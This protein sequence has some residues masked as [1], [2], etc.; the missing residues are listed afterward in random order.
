MVFCIL[1]QVAIVLLAILSRI[2]YS[3]YKEKI[4]NSIW[5]QRYAQALGNLYVLDKKEAYAQ[6]EKKVCKLISTCMLV[7]FISS[8]AAEL[9][10]CRQAE[11]AADRE[12]SIVRSDYTG[13]ATSET[14][15]LTM[16]DK[17]Y[18]YT[19]EIAPREYTQAEFIE[20]A[21]QQVKNLEYEILGNNTDFLHIN[22]NLNL[23]DCD[24]TGIFAYV[25]ES[26]H[27]E[28]VTPYGKVCVEELSGT[29]AVNLTVTICYLSYEWKHSFS[30]VVVEDVRRKD[31]FAEVEALLSDIE[32]NTRTEEKITL[33]DTYEA[34][35]IAVEKETSNQAAACIMFGILIVGVLWAGIALQLREER[36][37]RT[38]ALIRSYPFVVNQLWLLLETGMT[39][40]MG[41]R[42]II[43]EMEED[44]LLKK[45]LEYAMHQLDTGNEEAFVYEALGHRL[46]LPEYE[47]FMQH[48]SQH[49]RMGTKDL[50]NLMEM[51]VQAAQK[52]R[53]ELAKK[54][55]EEA[56]TKLLFPMIVLLALVMIIIIYPAL[57]GF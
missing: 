52:K 12:L 38:D 41:I 55:G 14:I 47:Q 31:A 46:K 45:E 54:K 3:K 29:V 40:Q 36:K 33:P 23:P 51:E 50:R 11:Q 16:D 17:E 2:H 28:L 43:S 5:V 15:R 30:L 48:I 35:E 39:I 42:K 21:E 34:V 57:S 4:R 49:I 26:D 8:A 1:I 53:R 18:N 56:S 24:A 20:Q 32:K 10:L 6:A 25:W 19:M 44:N 27:P 9:F 13:Q 22:R 37:K 7:L